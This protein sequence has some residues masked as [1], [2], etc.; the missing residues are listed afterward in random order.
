M[1]SYFLVNKHQ[2]EKLSSEI[3]KDTSWTRIQSNIKNDKITE[4]QKVLKIL[5]INSIY[6]E[7]DYPGIT[8]YNLGGWL[9]NEVGFIKSENE[10]DLPKIFKSRFILIEKICN[11]WYL[12][13]TT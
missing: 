11:N 12:Y 5:H 13:K 4:A 1:K 8:I 6:K 7:N 3:K 2:F 10:S 9:D